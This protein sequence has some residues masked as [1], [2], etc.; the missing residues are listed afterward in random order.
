M[1]GGKTDAARKS[2]TDERE[3]KSISCCSFNAITASTRNR[4]LDGG[5]RVKQS[6]WHYLHILREIQANKK[7]TKA[8]KVDSGMEEVEMLTKDKIMVY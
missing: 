1:I 2:R 8:A 4:G 5:R 7:A 6:L 3:M